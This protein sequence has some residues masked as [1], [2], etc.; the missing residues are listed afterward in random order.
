LSPL[1]L[2]TFFASVTIF[3]YVGDRANTWYLPKMSKFVSVREFAKICGF[4]HPSYA[5][6]AKS[7]FP[8]AVDEH[9]KIDIEHPEAIAF[10]EQ[11]I[12]EGGYADYLPGEK[13]TAGKAAQTRAIKLRAAPPVQQDPM[14]L[15]PSDI[16]DH[17]DKS[18][19]ELATMFGSDVRFVDWLKALRE[20]EIVHEK[21][22]KNAR[23]ESQ[24]VSR[25][26]VKRG[27]VDALDAAFRQMLTDGP[28]TITRRLYAKAK[29]GR[30]ATDGEEL[31]REQI[32][33]YLEGVKDALKRGLRAA[34]RAK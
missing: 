27:I 23:L 9:G 22:L 8:S 33:T 20:I 31:V 19:R 13:L 15:I 29:A 26:L 34:A 25:D 21:R 1:T 17:A 3:I 2:E 10:V 6:R 5:S 32:G 11:R 18:L 4:A 12:L 14:S 24:L 28:P 16:R 7:N 30:P